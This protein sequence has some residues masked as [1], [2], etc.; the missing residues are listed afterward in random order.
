MGFEVIFRG[1]N[2]ERLLNGLLITSKIAFI[3]VILACLFGL[4]FGVIM[5]S[6]NKFIRLICRVYLEIVRIIPTLVWLFIV[7]F[8]VASI[9]NIHLDGVFVAILVFVVWGTAEMG[10]L[11]RGAITSISVHQSESGKALGLSRLQVLR[12]ILIPQAVKRVIP[13]AI[14]LSTRMIKTSSLV[15]LIGVV[16]VIKVGQQII[17][18]SILKEPTVSFWVYALIFFLYFIICY[19]LSCL[20][21][22]LERKLEV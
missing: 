12:Y 18:N 6:K 11:V 17:E 10:D 1:N 13:G 8:G 7:Y 19:P 4:I 15:V 3:S 2:L 22:Y 14:N 9:L 20:S 16:E 5:T 21:R